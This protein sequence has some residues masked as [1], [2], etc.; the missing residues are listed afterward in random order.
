MEWQNEDLGCKESQRQKRVNVCTLH[1]HVFVS[2]IW[3]LAKMDV[4]EPGSAPT[5]IS[6]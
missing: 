6:R 4:L 1:V 3:P 5:G 2:Q